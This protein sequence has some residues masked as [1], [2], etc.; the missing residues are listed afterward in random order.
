MDIDI[1]KSHRVKLEY[2]EYSILAGEFIYIFGP[3]SVGKTTLAQSIGVVYTDVLSVYLNCNFFS[4]PSKIYTYILK[5]LSVTLKYKGSMNLDKLMGSSEFARLYEI[6]ERKSR[7]DGNPR[8]YVILDQVELFYKTTMMDSIIALSKTPRLCLMFCSTDSCDIFLNKISSDISRSRLGDMLNVI[9]LPAWSK[10]DIIDLICEGEPARFKTLYKKFVT[11][12]VSILYFSTTKNFVE[13]RNWCQANFEKFIEF[14]RTRMH[15]MAREE[16]ALDPGEIFED[17]YLEEY[18]TKYSGA[19]RLTNIIASYISSIEGLKPPEG[20]SDFNK[21]DRDRKLN[22]TTSILVVAAFVAANTRP[23][24]DKRNFV[25]FQKRR[26]SSRSQGFRD[27]RNFPLERLLQI[28]KGLIIISERSNPEHA[29]N[30]KDILKLRRSDL[31]NSVLSDVGLLEDLKMLEIVTGD[32][33]N[34]DTIF[35]L[36]S[37]ISYA[38]VNRLAHQVGLDLEHFHG[39]KQVS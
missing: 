36:S 32:G 9:Q 34:P 16:R 6:L 37:L 2:L 24:D 5:S 8:I 38:F 3:P 18:S 22:I 39:I 28:Y 11:N 29:C 15:E 13:I 33:L 30:E 1:V 4:S 35:K 19:Q 7:E 10:S 25:S 27:T 31:R 14:Y 12:I 20:R 17:D 26:A 21:L 23:N